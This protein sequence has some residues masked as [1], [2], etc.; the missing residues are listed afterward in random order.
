MDATELLKC[1]MILVENQRQS[2]I[3]LTQSNISLSQELHDLRNR[4][5]NL[6]SYTWHNNQPSTDLLFTE[7]F[8]YE[9]QL[10]THVDNC[11]DASI[12]AA[13]LEESNNQC[14]SNENLKQPSL[15]ND[16]KVYGPESS[17]ERIVNVS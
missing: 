15:A 5:D 2:I 17:V 10:E 12:G 8:G 7:L 1:L 16:N 9:Y 4:I 6:E 11:A 3:A 13:V 14:M